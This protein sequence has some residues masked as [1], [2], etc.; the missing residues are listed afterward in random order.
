MSKGVNCKKLTAFLLS[1]AMT[2]SLFAF[3]VYGEEAAGD[4]ADVTLQTS[5]LEFKQKTY[6]DYYD[7]ISGA[8]RPNTETIVKGTDFTSASDR[9]VYST[10]EYEGK[11]DVFVWENQEGDVTFDLDAPETGAYNLEFSYMPIVGGNTTTEISVMLDGESPYDTATRINLN[12]N[13][14]NKYDITVNEKGNQLRPPQIEKAVWTVAPLKDS[15]GLFSEPLLFFLEKGRHTLT[16]SSDRASFALEYIKLY[17]EQS[18]PA[19]ADIKGS[20]S[21]IAATKNQM[22]RLQAEEAT[23]KTHATLYPTSDRNSYL[24]EPS[25]PTKMRYN[26]MGLDSWN[27]AGQAASWEFT[28]DTA[29]YYKLGIK[30]RQATMRGFYSNR[31]IY[32]DGVVP[33]EEL[34]QVKFYYNT[35]FKTITPTDA[36]GNVIY[37]YLSEGTHTLTMEAIP[38]EIGDSMRRL[39][40]VIYDANQ[41]YLQML[42]VTSPQPDEFTDYRVHVQIPNLLTDF[43]TLSNRLIEEREKIEQLSKQ[44][45]SEAAALEKLA[46][47]YQKAID[48]PIKIPEQISSGAFKNNIS[49]V[50]AWMREYRDQPLEIDFIELA[51]ADMKFTSPKENF[52]KSMSFNGDAFIGSFF[53]DYTQLSDLTSTSVDVW[54]LS[55]RDQANVVKEMVDSNFVSS[56]NIDVSINLVQGGL[57]EAVMAGK[58]PDVALF[59][60]GEFPVSLACR[61]QLVPLS[62][63]KDF[64]EVKG[65]FLPDAMTPYEFEDK[66]YGLPCQQ[67]FPMMFYRTDVLAQLGLEPPETW[68]DLIDMMPAL[69]RNYLSA[70]LILPSAAIS[71][72]TEPGH[73]FA[74]L[75]LQSGQN[76]YNDEQTQTNFDQLKSVDAFVTWTEFYTKYGYEQVYDAFSRFRTGEMPVLIN[77]YASFYNQMLVTA[78]E[79]KGL[80]D[81]TS[82]PGTVREDGTISHAVNANGAG[83]LILKDCA[84]PEGAWEFIKWFSS[85]D[86]QI[87]YGR[88]IEGILGPMGRFEPA[89]TE[90]L[91]QMNWS[92]SDLKKIMAQR[93]EITEI[94][95]IP[96]SYVVTREII[97]AFRTTVNNKYNPRE[98]FLWSNRSINAEILRKR[99]DLGLDDE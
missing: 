69:Q 11:S 4:A 82:V 40:D 87:E 25:D 74:L 97:N 75:S 91:Q 7:E 63:F 9:T 86:V 89:N 34:A 24:T 50:S 99:R 29:G 78:P 94:P 45:G 30:A 2:S 52:F 95:I 46:V 19:Y 22:I 5:T 26:T 53:E 70:G 39:N 92:S 60:G 12:R 88:N 27:K 32:I 68:Q 67:I 96:S 43:E 18:R 31:R 15:D 3:P 10:G 77:N 16:I 79:I 76:Y 59:A 6:S 38:G 1:A 13:W 36:D 57:M 66:V 44:T 73:T 37:V 56:K 47:V 72:S 62:D 80:W 42:M 49:A 8:V 85:A 84:N 23:G 98:E 54:V 71:A 83:S 61:D 21:E 93:E 81:F 35:D 28:A 20:E 64:D 14:I 65:W 90:A 51:S 58:G 17:N 55:G 33:C 48:K 41:L